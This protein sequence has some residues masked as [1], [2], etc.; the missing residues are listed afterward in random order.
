M[1]KGICINLNQNTGV[2]H[3]EL[4]GDSDLFFCFFNIQHWPLPQGRCD[5]DS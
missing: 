2:F 3:Y 5:Y 4:N 1:R